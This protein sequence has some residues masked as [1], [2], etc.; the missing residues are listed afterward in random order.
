MPAHRRPTGGVVT[1][2]KAPMY[3]ALHKPGWLAG[4]LAA[5]D[6][7]GAV[8]DDVGCSITAVRNAVVKLGLVQR[9]AHGEVRFPQLHRRAWIRSR[10][11][12]QRRSVA[13]IASELGASETSV[14]RAIDRFGLA[15]RATRKPKPS[16]SR[17]QSD[18]RL[19][20][21]VTVIAR[22]HGVSAALAEVWL[23]EAGIFVRGTPAIPPASL[24][25][26]VAAGRPP[27]MIAE[28]YS[29]DQRVV[30]VELCRLA[31][32]DG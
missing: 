4:R 26:E 8:A 24:R 32:I 17:L 10:Y 14:Y 21:K 29:L 16:V 12:T 13:D 27:R 3:P 7:L 11:V 25:E 19:F 22:L 23:A 2:R 15:R 9:R 1:A 18:W 30:R 5:G 28:R 6:T 31:H 20:E